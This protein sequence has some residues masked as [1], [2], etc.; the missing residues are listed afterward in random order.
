MVPCFPI[1]TQLSETAHE[2]SNTDLQNCFYMNINISSNCFLALPDCLLCSIIGQ[3]LNVFHINRLDSAICSTKSRGNFL[4]VLSTLVDYVQ[5]CCIKSA[6]RVP[7]QGLFAWLKRKGMTTVSVTCCSD[8][9]PTRCLEYA[10]REQLRNLQEITYQNKAIDQYSWLHRVLECTRNLL[11][12]TMYDEKLSFSLVSVVKIN[13]INLRK[14]RWINPTD[15]LFDVSELPSLL[16]SL[17]KLK[18]LVLIKFMLP[19]RMLEKFVEAVPKVLL[20]TRVNQPKHT[21]SG[22][23]SFHIGQYFAG[24]SIV[25]RGWYSGYT[26]A[27]CFAMMADQ[28]WFT[29]ITSLEINDCTGVEA[30]LNQEC[31]ATSPKP[32]LTF[33]KCSALTQKTLFALLKCPFI[34]R[35]TLQNAPTNLDIGPINVSDRMLIVNNV[36]VVDVDVDEGDSDRNGEE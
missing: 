26:G 22:T 1:Y 35:L 23:S 28:T 32:A 25:Y 34:G 2:F 4:D 18:E 13:C 3:W 33:K 7:L 27:E 10:F 15:K 9:Y 29:P 24:V 19:E 14:F 20:V 31:L 6:Q 21:I 30:V 12:L 36:I 11:S 8:R 5:P 16:K 17:S